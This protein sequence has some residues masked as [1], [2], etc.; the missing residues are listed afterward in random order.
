ML[1]P[2]G[3]IGLVAAKFVLLQN[4]ISIRNASLWNIKLRIHGF[5]DDNYYSTSLIW[6]LTLYM[7]PISDHSFKTIK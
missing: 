3:V 7:V 1:R 4:F 6:V 5:L 2:Q